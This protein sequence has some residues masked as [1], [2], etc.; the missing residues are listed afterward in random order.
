A[1]N[2]KNGPGKPINR[3]YF[4]H[5]E[6]TSQFEGAERIA[7]QWG[8]T[9]DDADRFGLESQ[10]RAARAWAEGRFETQV[11]P[12]DAPVLGDDG[13]P[14]GETTRISRDEGLR[15]TTLEALAGLKPVMGDDGV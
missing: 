13:K 2:T 9:R 5:H 3:N 10:T 1:A 12:V 11:L 6:F 7:R 14:T 4:A 8:I 15:D